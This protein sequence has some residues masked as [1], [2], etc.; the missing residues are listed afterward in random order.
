[1]ELKPFLEGK[2]F[3]LKQIYSTINIKE[4]C[5]DALRFGITEM[6][7]IGYSTFLHTLDLL[8]EPLYVVL[9]LK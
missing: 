4:N 1:M 3:C 7:E 8:S 6:K 2:A 9:L 5:I